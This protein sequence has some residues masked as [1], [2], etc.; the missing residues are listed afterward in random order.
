MFLTIAAGVALICLCVLCGL[1]YQFFTDNIGHDHNQTVKLMQLVAVV[2]IGACTIGVQLVTQG[3]FFNN[4]SRDS[5]K[6]NFEIFNNWRELND[7]LLDTLILFDNFLKMEEYIS[8]CMNNYYASELSKEDAMI[9]LIQE[10]HFF[11]RAESEVI[12]LCDSIDYYLK[13]HI[14]IEDINL[15]DIKGGEKL[16]FLAFWGIK[17]AF[18]RGL[19]ELDACETSSAEKNIKENIKN[20]FREA[21]DDLSNFKR[22]IRICSAQVNVSVIRFSR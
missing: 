2:F 7:S 6:I 19:E 14:F 17:S 9:K 15:I 12:M 22:K 18:S 21:N 13:N 8:S 3:I 5:I 4:A 1:A 16:F 10:T 11:R 20:S